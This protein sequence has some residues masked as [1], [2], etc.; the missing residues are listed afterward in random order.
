MKGFLYWGH[1]YQQS[2]QGECLYLIEKVTAISKQ[3]NSLQFYATQQSGLMHHGMLFLSIN[4]LY[5]FLVQLGG[6]FYSFQWDTL[7]LET[8]W[9]VS[10][11]YAPWLTITSK[12]AKTDIPSNEVSTWPLRF[13]LFKLM[14]MSGVVK[15]QADCP[16]WNHLTALEYH[17]ATQCLPGPLAWYAHQL[18]PF[19]LR[20]GVAM[21]FL[22]E[23]QGAFFLIFAREVWREMG[24]VLQITLQVL[25]ILS[26]NYNFFNLLTILLCLPCL[27]VNEVTSEKN[28]G[29][30]NKWFVT[31]VR[32]KNSV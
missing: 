10:M 25:I 29:S 18:H 21:T 4:I 24:A 26:G 31:K 13:L 28:I 23:I 7:L 5:C 16:T 9:L 2:Q 27:E 17:F 11:C 22:I 3:T 14:F 32:F 6:T 1:Y 12:D 20:F 19:L 15:I 30:R 8:G